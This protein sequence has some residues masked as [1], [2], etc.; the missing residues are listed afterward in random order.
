M[1]IGFGGISCGGKTSICRQLAERLSG[2]VTFHMDDYYWPY[3]DPNYEAIP[4]YD[5]FF[6]WD[7]LSAINWTQMI[8][9]VNNCIASE[10][11][12]LVLVEGTMVL[13]NRPLA[14]YYSRQYFFTLPYELALS[15]RRL[16]SLTLYEPETYFD[17]YVW[18]S[19]IAC[20]ESLTHS[21]GTTFLDGS[22]DMA[23]N[24][25]HVLDDLSKLLD[26]NSLTQ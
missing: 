3:G 12:T 6:N 25:H 24:F 9:D 4:E 1:V 10:Q 11:T 2:V 7:C 5:S 18:P 22:L 21:D 8:T 15:R 14:A 13:N 16:K 17:R 26:H 23:D 19:Y 20:C